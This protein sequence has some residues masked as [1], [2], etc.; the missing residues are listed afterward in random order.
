MQT[1]DNV[2]F[3]KTLSSQGKALGS[4]SGL[5]S[6]PSLSTFFFLLI[7]RKLMNEALIEQMLLMEKGRIGVLLALFLFFVFLNTSRR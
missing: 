2:E 4:K 6:P 3:L 1:T 5:F 7:G